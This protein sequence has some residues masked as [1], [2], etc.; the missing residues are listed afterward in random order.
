MTFE[1]IGVTDGQQSSVVKMEL[2]NGTMATV[3][4]PSGLV[5]SFKLPLWH[6]ETLEMLH[7]QVLKGVDDD[8]VIVRGGIS[9]DLSLQSDDIG[10][11]SPSGWSLL[12][13]EGSSDTSIQVWSGHQLFN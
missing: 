8:D 10:I 13:V 4:L 3:M 5:T 7:T 9:L 1:T 11:W 2:D 12:D 6:G